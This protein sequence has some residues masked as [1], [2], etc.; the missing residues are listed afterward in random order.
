MPCQ[1]TQLHPLLI[2][3]S[4]PSEIAQEV[5][6]R[7]CSSPGWIGSLHI[8]HLKAASRRIQARLLGEG[9][10]AQSNPLTR[11]PLS[12][13]SSLNLDSERVRIGTIVRRVIRG[14]DWEDVTNELLL[15]THSLG[16]PL[17]VCEIRHAAIDFLR[18]LR[19]ISRAEEARARTGPPL[20]AGCTPEETDLVALLIKRSGIP[21]LDRSLIFDH[22]YIG[23]SLPEI[24]AARN[25]SLSLLRQRLSWIISQLRITAMLLNGETDE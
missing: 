2:P 18:H 25:F 13:D 7:L 10:R 5:G 3:G 4:P 19:V 1:T 11:Q 6:S 22:F 23:L 20:R 21:P 17:L 8:E 24:A 16:R 14:S 15:K 12:K 9:K